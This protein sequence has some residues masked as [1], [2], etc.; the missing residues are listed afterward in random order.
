M[1]NAQKKKLEDQKKKLKTLYQRK[2]NA[3]WF[4]LII[5][6]D[7]LLL[8]ILGWRRLTEIMLFY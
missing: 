5:E 8:L 6:S 2:K 4:G 1:Q 3:N 7:I